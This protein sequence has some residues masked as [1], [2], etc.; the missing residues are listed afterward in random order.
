MRSLIALHRP[1]TPAT[2]SARSRSSM[3]T[4]RCS[5]RYARYFA[6]HAIVSPQAACAAAWT[7]GTSS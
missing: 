5:S 6:N 4:R 3:D 1:A 7:P 2:A